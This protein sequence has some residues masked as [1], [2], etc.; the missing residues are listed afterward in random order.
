MESWGVC[1]GGEGAVAV[2]WEPPDLVAVRPGFLCDPGQFLSLS[3]PLLSGL[4]DKTP[5]SP[6]Q[7]EFL[8]V[9]SM[10]HWGYIWQ[11]HNSFKEQGGT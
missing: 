4:P 10:P 3:A 2:A 9:C 8:E 7:F 5:G 11:K 1:V 6:I